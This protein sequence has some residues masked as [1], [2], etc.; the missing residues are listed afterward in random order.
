MSIYIHKLVNDTSETYIDL[1]QVY[2][3]MYFEYHLSEQI[4]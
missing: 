2:K 3:Y 4:L 1:V